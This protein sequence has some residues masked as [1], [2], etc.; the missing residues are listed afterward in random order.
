MEAKIISM[1]KIQLLSGFLIIV[2]CSNKSFSQVMGN[3][4]AQWVTVKSANLKCWECKELLEKYI[5]RENKASYESGIL[6]WRFNLLQGEVR[7]QYIPDR[8]TP[9]DIRIIFNQAGFDADTT[10]AE[11][12]Y[13]KKLP[14][15]CKR[16]AD[17]GGPM[18]GKPCH[19]EPYYK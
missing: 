14:P 16:V 18:K 19:L 12:A 2:L 6:Q 5:I 11:D 3:T 9:E 10:K 8:V 15:N 7:L 4:K 1:K 13:Y 17:G